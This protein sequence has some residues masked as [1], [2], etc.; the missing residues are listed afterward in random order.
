MF[1]V[2]T[3]SV[4]LTAS[5]VTVAGSLPPGGVVPVIRIL[6]QSCERAWNRN[7][8]ELVLVPIGWFRGAV[9]VDKPAQPPLS[10]REIQK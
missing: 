1:A 5:K 6:R 4:K 3:P 8:T 9:I 10:S 7:E 2:Y